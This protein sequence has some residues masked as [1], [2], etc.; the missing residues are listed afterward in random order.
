MVPSEL[1]DFRGDE[2][3][4]RIEFRAFSGEEDP[5]LENLMLPK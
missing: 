5:D 3:G 4:L 1:L 2:T